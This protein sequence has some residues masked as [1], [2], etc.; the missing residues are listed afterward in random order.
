LQTGDELERIGPDLEV[1]DDVE[2]VFTLPMPSISLIE[3]IPKTTP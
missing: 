1:D 2:M 3:L